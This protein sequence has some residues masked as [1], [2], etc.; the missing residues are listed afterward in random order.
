MKRLMRTIMVTVCTLTL[1]ACGGGGGGGGGGVGPSP[2]VTFTGTTPAA[3]EIYLV[4]NAVRSSGSVLAIDVKANEVSGAVFGTAFDLDF[5][6]PSGMTYIGHEA[7]SFLDESAGS[8][9]YNSSDMGGGKI[10]V[11]ASSPAGATGATGSG[12]IITLKFG[13]TDASVLS[14]SNNELRD[15]ANHAIS[16][17]WQGGDVTVL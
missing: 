17:T 16:V 7:G 13:V 10:V 11:G 2:T 12:T 3:N 8:V 1:A 15:S 4:R 9:I 6:N 14:F 5:S